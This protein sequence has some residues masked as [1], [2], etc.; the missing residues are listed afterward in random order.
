VQCKEYFKIFLDPKEFQRVMQK[1]PEIAPASME[2]VEKMYTD[3]LTCL[4]NHISSTLSVQEFPD[5]PWAKV[6]VNFIFSVPTTWTSQSVVERFRRITQAA[7]FGSVT[8]HQ[9]IVGLTEAEAAAVHVSKGQPNL[10]RSGDVLLMCDAGGGTTDLSVLQVSS[11]IA[12]IL[13]LHQVD[14][15][16]GKNIGS[17][18]IDDDFSNLV[19]E[20]LFAADSER[21]SGLSEE[22]ICHQAWDATNSAD[23]QNTKCEFGNASTQNLEFFNCPL[24]RIP[25]TYHND[26]HGIRAQEITIPFADLKTI[27]DKQVDKL[28]RHIDSQVQRVSSHKIKYLILSGGLGHSA[29]VQQQLKARYEVDSFA[30]YPIMVR[31]SLDPQLAVCMGLVKD[32]IQRLDT[33]HSALSRRICRES[34]GVQCDIPDT[35]L[36]RSIYGAASTFTDARDGKLYYRQCIRWLIKQGEPVLADEALSWDFLRLFAPH[37]KDRPYD[38]KLLKS[39]APADSIPY[40][41]STGAGEDFSI[42]WAQAIAKHA[43]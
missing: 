32:R 21:P 9:V 1:A 12:D 10:F 4:Y 25:F 18:A 7:G 17:V 30:G 15:V 5:R 41:A 16:R 6:A 24:R 34:Y 38:V 8:S 13:D 14:F 23:Y 31:V 37:D 29:Y 20:R 19:R 35:S 39:S 22:E 28:F 40:V 36:S 2:E 42:G 27:F 43:T 33:G 26:R 3:Y 11:N